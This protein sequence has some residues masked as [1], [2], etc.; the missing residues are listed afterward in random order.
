MSNEVHVHVLNA[1]AG[2]S[3]VIEFCAE[4]VHYVVIDCNL[5]ERNSQKINPAYEFL[6]SEMSRLSAP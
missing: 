3:I 4:S 1:G 5:V 6:K 2:D